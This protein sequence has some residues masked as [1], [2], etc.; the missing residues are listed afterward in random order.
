MTTSIVSAVCSLVQVYQQ[1]TKPEE[2]INDWVKTR[3]K[4]EITDFLTPGSIPR[5]VQAMLINAVY[6]KG[7]WSSKFDDD[8]TKPLPFFGK[9]FT[10]FRMY[11]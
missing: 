8:L 3:T 4:G 7:R 10:F 5:S 11:R 6:F 9:S 1:D 2:A